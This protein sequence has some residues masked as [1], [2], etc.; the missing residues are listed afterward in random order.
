MFGGSIIL[1]TPMLFAIGFLF[2]FTIGGL[3]GI[4]LANGG[5]DVALHDTCTKSIRHEVSNNSINNTTIEKNKNQSTY[6]RCNEIKNTDKTLDPEYIKQ[7]WVGLM[8]GDGSIQ[9]NHWRKKN[10]QFRLVIKLLHTPANLTMLSLIQTHIGGNVRLD[11]KFVL[12]VV[13]DRNHIR[14]II[15]ILDNYPPLT[16]RL[17]CQLL[18]LKECL[19]SLDVN[20]YLNTRDFK[21]SNKSSIIKEMANYEIVNLSYFKAW[22]SGFTEAEG[23]FC[24]RKNNNHSFSIAQKDDKY[25][26]EAIKIYFSTNNTVRNSKSIYSLEIYKKD[27]LNSI[28]THFLHYPLLGEKLISFQS[29]YSSR[30]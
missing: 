8:D 30:L 27:T 16:S 7:F 14:S 5:L 4:A 24:L 1:E 13:N 25:L 9:V 15:K 28:F 18:F 19:N 11:K 17:Q 6:L 29:F 10:L 2:L 23:C 3:T 21:Y 26:L 12:W 20:F 22:L